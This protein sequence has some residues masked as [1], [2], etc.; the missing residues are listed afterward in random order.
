EANGFELSEVDITFPLSKL[1]VVC[2][3]TASGKSSVLMAILGEMYRENVGLSANGPVAF[4]SQQAWLLNETVRDNIL[5]G[6]EYDEERYYKV[7]FACSLEKNLETLDGGDMTEFGEKG[8]NVSG[9]QKQRISFARAAYSD[10]EYIFLDDCL[11]AVDAPSA[12]HLLQHCILGL[13][14]SRTRVL[15]TNAWRRTHRNDAFTG[16]SLF[17]LLREPILVFPDTLVELIDTWV[18]FKRIVKYLSPIWELW[19]QNIELDNAHGLYN[20]GELGQGESE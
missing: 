5:F 13:M 10:S 15:V 14:G 6:K 16:H 17:A 3:A 19:F 8:I 1:T 2:G 12:R 9:G 7:L 20:G 4:V 11:S 18:S